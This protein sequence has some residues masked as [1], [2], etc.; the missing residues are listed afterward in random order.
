VFEPWLFRDGRLDFSGMA[1][2]MLGHVAEEALGRGL[3]AARVPAGL[4]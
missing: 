1:G 3:V 2:P 4:V